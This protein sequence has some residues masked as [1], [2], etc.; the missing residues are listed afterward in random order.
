MSKV[1]KLYSLSKQVEIVDLEA[2]SLTKCETYERYKTSYIEE[3]RKR[4]KEEYTFWQ[5]NGKI[6]CLVLFVLLLLGVGSVLC[7]KIKNQEAGRSTY[8]VQKKENETFPTITVEEDYHALAEKEQQVENVSPPEIVDKPEDNSSEDKKTET[9][10]AVL[11]ETPE[12]VPV[13]EIQEKDDEEADEIPQVETDPVAIEVGMVVS[14]LGNFHYDTSF[15]EGIPTKC[16]AGKAVVT[17]ISLDQ[18]HPYHL[19][20]CEEGCTV[21]GWVNAEDISLDFGA[22]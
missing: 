20:S 5:Q 8:E 22:E 19:E 18:V 17:K 21:Y 11:D 16:T 9:N 2:H 10:E 14:F 15:A 4:R 1:K 7:A 13:D 3:C 6:I 12:K